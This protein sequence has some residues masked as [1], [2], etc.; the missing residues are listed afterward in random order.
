M[1]PLAGFAPDADVTTPGVITD[2]TN[3]IPY[4]VGMEGGPSQVVP[5][6]VPTLASDCR[7][8]VVTTKL[9]D[10]RRIFAG[11]ATKLYELVSGAWTDQSAGSYTGGTDTRWSFTQ[12]GDSTIASNL[13]DAMQRSTTGAFAAIASAPKAD[14]VFSVGAFVMA[15]NVNDGT[16]KPNGW[17]CCAAFDETTWTPSV[18]NQAN[19]G[20]LV[21][22]PGK[23]TAGLRL[24]EYAVAYKAKSIYLGTYVGSPAVWNWLL[25]LGGEAGCVGKDALC[26]IGGA[27]FFVGD[28]NI[29]IFDGTRPKS[30][31]DGSVRQWFFNNSNPTYRYKT[32]CVFDRQNNRVWMFYVSISG[33]TLDSALVYHVAANKW[34]RADQSIEAAFNYIQP[35]PTIDTLT[36]YSATID[37]LPAQGLDSQFWMAGG[38]FL[39]VVNTSHQVVTLTGNST[40]SNF[41]TGDGGDDDTVSCLKKL[42]L[43]YMTAPTSATVQTYYRMQSG[44]TYTTGSSGAINDGK[45]D[46]RQSG[47]WHKAKFSFTGPVQVTQVE[48]QYSAAGQR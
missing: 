22:T 32:T 31:A 1:T 37:G 17:A 44:A 40:S 35:T 8:G 2:C 26:D 33:S 39:T 30:I 24:G 20:L 15:L 45:F 5:G 34:G 46:T 12:F 7:N 23:L 10:T 41:T 36:N 14:I 47:R 11:T 18:T 6:S 25:V 29:W 28:D 27:H 38:R 4:L 9:D 48:A 13:T 16:V 19:N 42:R 21:A 43:R 3:F